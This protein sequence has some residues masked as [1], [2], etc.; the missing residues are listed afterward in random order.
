MNGRANRPS[1]S[2]APAPPQQTVGVRRLGLSHNRSLVLDL[3][4][5]AAKVPRFGVDRLVDL[6]EL[7]ELRRQAA[8]RISW[9]VLF[10]KAHALVAANVRQL[11]Q[12]HVSWPWP[13]LIEAPDSVAI[14]AINRRDSQREEDRLCWGRFLQPET[15]S[16]IELQDALEQ[17]QKQPLEEI[18]WRQVLY[19]RMPAPLRRLSWWLNL[20]M[21]V[22]KRARRMGTFSISTLAGDGCWNR[23]HPSMLTT[24]LSYGPLDERGQSLVTLLCDHRVLDEALAA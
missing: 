19:S 13:H 18:F 20:N 5:F 23:S 3:L 24:S 21:F 8:R 22:G 11:R 16:L 1:N 10:M 15:K 14:L 7:A 12:A 17:Y 2:C 9:A 6:A 4:H